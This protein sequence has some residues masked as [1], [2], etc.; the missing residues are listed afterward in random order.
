MLDMVSTVQYIMI[1]PVLI[2]FF[3]NNILRSMHALA[4]LESTGLI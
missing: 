2:F 3:Y 4:T 1:K